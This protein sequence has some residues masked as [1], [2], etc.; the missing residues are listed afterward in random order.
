LATL[1]LFWRLSK[2]KLDNRAWKSYIAAIFIP[3]EKARG[4]WP[5]VTALR[6]LAQRRSGLTRILKT[7]FNMER[8]L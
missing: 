3:Q 7:P 1:R 6:K 4:A 8:S 5:L 2:E